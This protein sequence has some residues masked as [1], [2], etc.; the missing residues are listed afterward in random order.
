M[1]GQQGGQAQEVDLVWTGEGSRPGEGKASVR[2]GS[3]EGRSEMNMDTILIAMHL[4]SADPCGQA[5][6]SSRQPSHLSDPAFK[7]GLIPSITTP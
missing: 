1:K 5:Q 6:V 2:T 3:W 7:T 4:G